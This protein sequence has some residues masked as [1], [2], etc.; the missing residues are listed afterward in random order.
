MNV[1]SILLLLLQL[2]LMMP[3]ISSVAQSRW[4]EEQARVW[5]EEQGWRVGCNFIPSNAINQ[6]EM[7]QAETFDSKTIDRE[8]GYAGN[9]GFNT[10]RVYL[11]DLAYQQDPEGL[12]Q[13]MDQ[14]LSI[15]SKYGIKTLF[16]IF[17]DCWND[18]CDIGKQPEPVLGK[19]NSGWCQSPGNA[20]ANDKSQWPRLETYVLDIL[21]TF[22]EDD[23]ILMWDLYNEPG[24]NARLGRSLP[25]LKKV[26]EW[27]RSVNPDQPLTAGV[28]FSFKRLNKFQLS[29]SDII[30]FHNYKAADNL[31]KEIAKLK[32]YD[33]PIICTE[34]MARNLNSTVE[35]CLPV[36]KRENVG[37][38]NWGLVAGKTNTIFPWVNTKGEK[39]PELWFHDLFRQ[40]GT[41]YQQ[42]E[43]D[44][45]KTLIFD[46]EVKTELNSKD[47][48]RLID[49]K[50]VQLFSLSN[51]NGLQ[52][53]ITN[54]GGKVVSLLVPDRNGKLAD[55]VLGFNDLD[56]YLN[57]NEPYFGA[58]IGRYGNRIANGKFTLDGV[59]Y[60]LATNNG[61][62]HLH[63]GK[64]GFNA[65]VWDAQQID[66]QTLELTYLSKDGEEGYPGNLDVKVIYQLSNENELSIT[67][68]A[69]TDKATP[70]NLTHHSFFN[71]AGEGNG[72]I[73]DHLLWIDADRYTPVNEGLIPTGELITVANTPFDFRSSTAIGKRVNE[74][75]AQLKFGAGYDHNFV[76]N[77]GEG[78]RKVAEVKEP[79][80]GRIMEVWTDEP[81]L[82]FYGGNFLDGS[83]LGKQGKPYTLRT[84]FC[85]E[86]QHFPDS[87]NRPDFPNTILKSGE[88]YRTTCVYKFRTD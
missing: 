66:E 8:L 6:L 52:T 80:F 38:I 85:L 60:T 58:L 12:K 43:V 32:E 49:G 11:H 2:L 81:G 39:E 14:F 47:F 17:D 3:P 62:N 9:I 65:V 29:N 4:T 21:T 13:R 34:W 63:G 69:K 61:E 27:A 25:L 22:K 24:N 68:E 73:N 77:K 54:Y 26:F 31:E 18:K 5:S 23:R 15:A 87:P 19:H 57:A 67:Y 40:N 86:T 35:A 56:G 41:P 7:W 71:L 76:L 42:E 1:F 75:N 79:L 16:V 88:T 83:D 45:F 53:Y 28:W 72:T 51:S 55:V 74:E 59:E 20:V 36:F 78:I 33:R 10:V 44:L 84:A 70:V 64:K 82:Q 50:Q 30:T 46:S 37:C 48:E